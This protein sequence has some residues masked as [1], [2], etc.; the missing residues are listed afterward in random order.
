MKPWKG[1]KQK[2]DRSDFRSLSW[3]GESVQFKSELFSPL[4]RL[5]GEAL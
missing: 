4:A 2:P 5:R 1:R 3:E